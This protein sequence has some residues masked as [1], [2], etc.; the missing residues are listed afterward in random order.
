MT[1]H[2][3]FLIG[4]I[5]AGERL[6]VVLASPG[7]G[8]TLT[9]Q[10]TATRLFRAGLIDHVAVFAPRVALAQGHARLP[11]G[12]QERRQP[13]GREPLAARQGGPHLHR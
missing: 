10:A 5:H 2:H 3:F 8:K 13:G 1:D 6:T 11:P 4:R 7:S 12:L 9:Y